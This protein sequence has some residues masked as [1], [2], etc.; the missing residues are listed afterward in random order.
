MLREVKV[1]TGSRGY[2]ANSRMSVVNGGKHIRLFPSQG[3]I[4]KMKTDGWVTASAAWRLDDDDVIGILIKKSEGTGIK[5]RYADDG[6]HECPHIPVPTKDMGIA[7][8]SEGNQAHDACEDEDEDDGFFFRI[9][10]G[11]TFSAI[12]GETV[13]PSASPAASPSRRRKA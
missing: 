11:I 9:R 4:E 6:R 3:I 12:R 7:V 1:T 5:I 8:V 2:S 13:S 10:D